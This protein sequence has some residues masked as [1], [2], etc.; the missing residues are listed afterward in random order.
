[1]P[2]PPATQPPA[3]RIDRRDGLHCALFRAM[4]SPCEVLVDARSDAD[5]AAAIRIAAAEAWR[6]EQAFSRYR[7]DNCVHRINTAGGEPITVDE[8]LARLLDF[9]D[10]CHRLSEGLFDITAGVLRRAWRFD[11]GARPP[12]R[13][14]LAALL[15][16]VG[17]QRVRWRRPVLQLLPGMEIDLGGIGKEYAVDRA[18]ALASDG[19]RVACLVNFGGD[20]KANRPP[21]GRD[22]W[23]IGVEADGTAFDLA[24]GACTTSGDTYRH[25]AYRG[26]RYGHI[27]D[28]RTGYPVSDAPRSVTVRGKTC[29][30]TGVLATLAMLKGRDAEAF[31]DAQ[32]VDYRVQR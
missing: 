21:T 12:T 13:P 18:L 11:P 14:A 32:G 31:L 2:S 6:I 8:E 4:G 20:L 26:R 3:I 29:T 22:A 10:D 17:W 24:R 25:L 19:D 30:E 7:D 16:L 28:P 15:P 9:A 1:M 27:L 23:R 5:A